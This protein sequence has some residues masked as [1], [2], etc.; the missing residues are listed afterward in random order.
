MRSKADAYWDTRAERISEDA[1]VNCADSVQRDME[2]SAIVP[3]LEK[4]M[5][6]L[7][8]GCGN[9]YSTSVLRKLV[10]HVD[11]F[12]RSENMIE[13]ARR[14]FGETNYRFIVDDLLNPKHLNEAYDLAL[15][16]RVLINLRDVAEQHLALDNIA[17]LVATGGRF[18]LVEGFMD[19]FVALNSVRQKAGMPPLEPGEVS[20]YGTAHEIQSYLE[21]HFRIESEFHLGSYDYL[22]RFVY[23]GIVGPENAKHN[24]PLHK[25]FQ[26]LASSHNPDCL[27]EFSRSRG[28]V[29]TKKSQSS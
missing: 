23:P 21:R 22:T 10:K 7:E 15:C 5:R 20:L 13:R 27:K 9:G 29:M 25:Q 17:S 4:D 18:I 12:D 28:F 19:G 26:K 8:V 3:Y 1:D 2:L 16:V 6:V 11:A 14:T 24:T